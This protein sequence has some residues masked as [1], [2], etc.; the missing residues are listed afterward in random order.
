MKNAKNDQMWSKYQN[1]KRIMLPLCRFDAAK[2]QK[3]AEVNVPV[4]L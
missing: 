2:V 3:A 4:I 1:D